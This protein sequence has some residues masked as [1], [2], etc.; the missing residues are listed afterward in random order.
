LQKIDRDISGKV[1]TCICGYHLPKNPTPIVPGSAIEEHN[2]KQQH[3]IDPESTDSEHSILA[4][5]C[6]KRTAEV[7]G[8]SIK[9][10]ACPVD[11]AKW[12][13]SQV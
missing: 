11:Q 8:V 12:M 2:K 10:F 3:P 7:E 6:S 1:T 4:S 9:D 13:Q 5:T